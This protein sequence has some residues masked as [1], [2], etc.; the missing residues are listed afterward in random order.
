MAFVGFEVNCTKDKTPAAEWDLVQGQEEITAEQQEGE[1]AFAAEHKA[2]ADF[3]REWTELKKQLA[4]AQDAAAAA[5]MRAIAGEKRAAAAEAMAAELLTEVQLLRERAARREA[6]CETLR[7]TLRAICEAAECPILHSPCED[8]V[9]A[10]DGQTYERKALEPWLQEQGTSPLT[11]K[12]LQPYIYPN[13]FAAAVLQH[14]RAA[15]LDIFQDYEG[16]EAESGARP[17]DAQETA[18][19]E[20]GTLFEA[21]DRHDEARALRLLQRPQVPDLNVVDRFGRTVLHSAILQSHF[22]V[23]LEI[24]GRQDFP[25]INARLPS[26]S[27]AL[28]LAVRE[29]S[30]YVVRAIVG[31]SDFT[32]LLAVDFVGRTA[33]AY[34]D[35]A[36]GQSDDEI[37]RFL[38]Q[39]ESRR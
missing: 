21:V 37:A 38:R 6:E 26:G 34:A 10:S 18:A 27:T 23:A 35:D 25:L 13:R 14:L 16:D 20:L 11:R 36:N 17:T 22:A 7:V 12:W 9:V 39:A 32:E 29:E 1:A 31:R 2:A 3:V 24:V 5:E 19:L 8:P 28:H 33:R 4:A 30:F 15:A